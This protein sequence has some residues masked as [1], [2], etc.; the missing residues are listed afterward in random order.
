MKILLVILFVLV[1][2][3]IVL[4]KKKYNVLTRKYN[5]IT[6]PL[7]QRSNCDWKLLHDKW[8]KY[9]LSD[10]L[11]GYIYNYENKNFLES[12]KKSLGHTIVSEYFDKFA[13][14][15]Q[16]FL[17]Y[18]GK[19]NA[20]VFMDILSEAKTIHIPKNTAVCHVRI[21]RAVVHALKEFNTNHKEVTKD[22]TYDWSRYVYPVHYYQSL[23]PRLHSLNVTNII[24]VG[25]T[26]HD[27]AKWKKESYKYI[28]FLEDF[29]VANEFNVQRRID[30]NTPDED[31][32]FMSTA[33][34]FIRGGGGFS[35]FIGKAVTLHDNKVLVGDK[36]YIPDSSHVRLK[37][38]TARLYT[39]ETLTISSNACQLYRISFQSTRAFQTQYSLGCSSCSNCVIRT[40]FTRP[41]NYTVSAMSILQEDSLNLTD[42]TFIKNTLTRKNSLPV[43][44]SQIEVLPS[45]KPQI[46]CDL[47]NWIDG[48]WVDGQWNTACSLSK[49]KISSGW[50]HMYGDSVQRG[51]HQRMCKQYGFK[52]FG[53]SEKDVNKRSYN[54][55]C[56]N[57]TLL[58]TCEWN[59][60]HKWG[61]MGYK[62]WKTWNEISNTSM[63]K[64]NVVLLS[65]GSHYPILSV[66]QSQ[67]AYA[68][69]M[70][71]MTV[72][73]IM[74]GITA[75]DEFRIPKHYWKQNLSQAVVRN[76]D[77]IYFKNQVAKKLCDADSN[78]LAYIDLFNMSLKGVPK[79][80][81]DA[82]HSYDGYSSYLQI[83]LYIMN[84]FL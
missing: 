47:T 48:D 42:H 36:H 79:I 19:T 11:H 54:N 34:I 45:S 61:I 26:I 44:H 25:S 13:N 27:S 74:Q 14:I 52:M 16:N 68:N 78:C 12:Y 59:Y 84:Y 76:N 39:N 57:D 28:G 55:W 60:L 83:I 82:V 80:Y 69:A 63:Q 35:A 9:R 29:F 40:K 70:K 10:A 37:L 7:F 77:R 73:Y 31:F 66:Q 58:I 4:P 72:R 24:M 21:G 38:N 1:L 62:K 33:P 30:C 17:K 56:K 23:V 41:G 22:K 51:I 50:I 32:V 46:K 5:T 75:V 43:S 2:F 64:P 49:N 18:G 67:V 65:F 6:S 3:N 20:K 8:H 53:G 81:G 71:K 15:S